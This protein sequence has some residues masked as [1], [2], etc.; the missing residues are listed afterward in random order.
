[1]TCK[2]TNFVFIKFA[3]SRSFSRSSSRSSSRFSKRFFSSTLI[4]S[5]SRFLFFQFFHQSLTMIF[6]LFF[7]VR[8]DVFST[9]FAISNLKFRKRIDENERKHRRIE[10]KYKKHSSLIFEDEKTHLVFKTS[11]Y[12][13]RNAIK[14]FFSLFFSFIF[15]FLFRF[16]SLISF[17]FNHHHHFICSFFHHYIC[18][19]SQFICV[20]SFFRSLVNSLVRVFL[21]ER[22]DRFRV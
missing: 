1:M 6:F 20:L 18:F 12:H 2:L 16:F 21:V 13:E 7:I 14:A 9:T 19:S 8:I 17:S 11:H 15:W 10:T 5:R 22:V 4:W 3:F